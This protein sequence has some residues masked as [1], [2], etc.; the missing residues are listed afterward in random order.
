MEACSAA[1]YMIQHAAEGEEP[2]YGRSGVLCELIT[3]LPVSPSRTSS[4]LIRRD[5]H[6]MIARGLCNFP[7]SVRRSASF[8]ASFR[9][10]MRRSA[11]ATAPCAPVDAFALFDAHCHPQ[12]DPEHALK[13][14]DVKASAVAAMGTHEDDWEAVDQLYLSY[15][16]KVRI[17]LPHIRCQSCHAGAPCRHAPGAW[18]MA[19]PRVRLGCVLSA[20]LRPTREGRRTLQW[21]ATQVTACAAMQVHPRR[22]L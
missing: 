8:V 6:D 17:G 9:R 3:P 15:P 12:D 16:N 10:Q 4:A 22:R 5:P 13:L 21:T 14:L 7:T 11:M 19:H 20:V 2:M 1:R 18:R